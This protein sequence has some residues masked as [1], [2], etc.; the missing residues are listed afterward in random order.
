[1]FSFFGATAPGGFVVGGV[2]STIFAQWVWWS[3]GYWVMG[4]C[5]VL[6]GMGFLVILSSSRPKTHNNF[7]VIERLDLLGA[8]VGIS[9]LVLINFA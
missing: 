3:W 4:V 9:G 1:M 7:N 5:F 8:A 6:A 2:F